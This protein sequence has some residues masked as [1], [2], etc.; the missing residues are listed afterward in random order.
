MAGPPGSLQSGLLQTRGEPLSSPGTL[1][2]GGHNV[3]KEGHLPAPS[4][5]GRLP[6][7][8]SAPHGPR[9]PVAEWWT[10]C[11]T[12]GLD[13]GGTPKV[14]EQLCA[15]ILPSLIDPNSYVV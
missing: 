12:G 4:Q 2:A 9:S 5:E 10:A 8:E 14:D 7:P 11:P 15:T 3:Q 13:G 6:I 1:P